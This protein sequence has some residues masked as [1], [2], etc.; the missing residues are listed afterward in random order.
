MLGEVSGKMI[1]E[2]PWVIANLGHAS[3]AVEWGA[4]LGFF[5]AVV[6]LGLVLTRRRAV[7]GGE[8]ATR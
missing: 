3:P 6:A 4:R 5:A 1:V 7:T 2:D 8:P